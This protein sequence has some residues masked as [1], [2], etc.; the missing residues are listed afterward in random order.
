MAEPL[1][2]TSTTDIDGI[3]SMLLE[4]LAEGRDADVVELVVKLLRQ[5]TQDNERLKL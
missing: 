3:Q 1:R 4:L 5:L 2:K